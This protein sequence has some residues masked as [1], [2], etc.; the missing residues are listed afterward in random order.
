MKELFWW[1]LLSEEVIYFPFPLIIQKL[2]Y[3]DNNE[4]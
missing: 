3:K 2:I 1:F 4:K